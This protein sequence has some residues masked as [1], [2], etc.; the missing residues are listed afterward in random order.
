MSEAPYAKDIIIKHS[1]NTIPLR[2]NSFHGGSMGMPGMGGMGMPSYGMNE[3]NRPRGGRFG[4]ERRSMPISAMG[5]ARGIIADE[6]QGGH[7]KN[8]IPRE[9]QSYARESMMRNRHFGGGMGGS[10]DFRGGQMGGFNG[11]RGGFDERMDREM[12]D[13]MMD[14]RMN[15]GGGGRRGGGG[16]SRSNQRPM[17]PNGAQF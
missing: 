13:R 17:R 6:D 16:S 8:D 5:G 3:F 12:N 1:Q 15:G 2:M 7:L 11:P 9:S 4:G 14:E 10:G